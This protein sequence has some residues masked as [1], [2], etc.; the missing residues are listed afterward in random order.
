MFVGNFV[1]NFFPTTLFFVLG[2]RASLYLSSSFLLNLIV[3]LSILWPSAFAFAIASS[4]GN[5][6][7]VYG[8]FGNPFSPRIKYPNHSPGGITRIFV[9][10]MRHEI[11]GGS[12][13]GRTGYF[14]F[15]FG[16]V[17]FIKICK[18]HDIIVKDL[19]LLS[20]GKK[21]F[22]C[23]T[24]V[25]EIKSGRS[26]FLL[27]LFTAPVKPMNVLKKIKVKNHRSV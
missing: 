17:K 4:D 12:K 22:E 24:I 21:Q 14:S 2:I 20:R 16:V 18:S 10:P 6:L 7:M 27:H 26:N 3:F 15:S 25:F 11:V 5:P 13:D 1:E 23:P 9:C 8:N 19:V